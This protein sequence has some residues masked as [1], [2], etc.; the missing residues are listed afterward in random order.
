[1]AVV[2]RTGPSAAT[3]AIGLVVLR[4]QVFM[5]GKLRLRFK[6]NLSLFLYFHVSVVLQF[7]SSESGR[8]RR[9]FY[10]VRAAHFAGV[11]ILMIVK[12]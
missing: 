9:S 12:T 3:V 8:V 4:L 2:A 7:G 1:M 5:C 6:R 10:R 11:R